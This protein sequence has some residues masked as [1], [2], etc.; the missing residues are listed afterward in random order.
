MLLDL[1][2][3]DDSSQIKQDGYPTA[4]VGE[5]ALYIVSYQWIQA[6]AKSGIFWVTL[7]N[8]A[9]IILGNS[10]LSH[11]GSTPL[12]G[13]IFRCVHSDLSDIKGLQPLE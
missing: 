6:A 9:R 7:S 11:V 2:Y 10:E 13:H 12:G 8:T 4:S 3:L 1:I 5:Q